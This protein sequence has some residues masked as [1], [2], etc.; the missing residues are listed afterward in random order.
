M[1][2]AWSDM[3]SLGRCGLER[4]RGHSHP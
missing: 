4:S 1:D 3:D 2:I